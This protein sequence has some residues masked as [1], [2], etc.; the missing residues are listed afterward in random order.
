MYYLEP[1]WSLWSVWT[2]CSVIGSSATCGNGI[3]MRNRN[4]TNSRHFS[5]CGTWLETFE[6]NQCLIK[7]VSETWNGWS[8]WR[9]PWRTPWS[10]FKLLQVNY[11]ENNSCGENQIC[12][13]NANTKDYTCNCKNGYIGK[14]RAPWESETLECIPGKII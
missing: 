7:C 8:P 14:T 13:S 6:S 12:T 2:K 4:C 5:E 3:K 10:I 1:G 9:T 11:C